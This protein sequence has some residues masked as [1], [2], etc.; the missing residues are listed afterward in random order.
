MLFQESQ[1]QRKKAFIA[2][3]DFLLARRN[4]NWLINNE[5]SKFSS[6]DDVTKQLKG[7]CGMS[8]ETRG[9]DQEAAGVA[10][11]CGKCTEIAGLL[12]D[13]QD[14]CGIWRLE[15]PLVLY[16][17]LKVKRNWRISICILDD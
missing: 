13:M 11:I 10:E 5:S 12:R 14:I 8:C 15:F 7:W 1:V 2:I 4:P 3:K 16:F 6:G 17:F 9:M